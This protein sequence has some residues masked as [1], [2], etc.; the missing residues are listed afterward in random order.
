MS[1]GERAALLAT[2]SR[3]D[4]GAFA[5]TTT[6]C[7]VEVAASNGVGA[8]APRSSA[9]RRRSYLWLTIASTAT[10]AIII[11]IVAR[12][13]AAAVVDAPSATAVDGETPRATI[14]MMLSLIHI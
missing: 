5:P 4:G 12:V 14:V 1:S 9:W 7:D 2:P 6:E 8:N 3:G 13:S 11:T 10:F